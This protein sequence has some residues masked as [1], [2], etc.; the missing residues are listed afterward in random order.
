LTL[1]GAVDISNVADLQCALQAVPEPD[2]L[3]IDMST[4]EF[5]DSTALAALVR[6]R[7]AT[8]ARGGSVTLVIGS[9]LV[10]RI[11]DITNFDREFKIV[12]HLEDVPG[13][14]PKA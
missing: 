4:V 6:Y 3:V 1:N 13:L 8:V 10:K 11:F 2:P 5:L 7:N 12:R 9:P 14:F